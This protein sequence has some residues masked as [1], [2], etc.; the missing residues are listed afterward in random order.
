MNMI[1]VAGKKQNETINYL[2]AVAMLLVIFY[3]GLGYAIGFVG[4]KGK[5]Y[6]GIATVISAVNVPLFLMIAGYLSRPQNVREYYKKR[7]FRILIPFFVFTTVKLAAN[8]TIDR[9]RHSDAVWDEILLAYVYGEY[10][11]FSYAFFIMSLIA[12]LLWKIKNKTVLPVLVLLLLVL[13]VLNEHYHFWSK[14]GLFQIYNVLA[15]GLWFLIGYALQ[16]TGTCELIKRKSVRHTALVLSVI[17]AALISFLLF[18]EMVNKY[19]GRFI[20][21][22]SFS[23]ILYYIFTSIDFRMPLLSGVSKYTYQLFLLD[24]FVKVIL[25]AILSRLLPINLLTVLIISALNV[26]IGV[27]ICLV[28]NKIK[29]AK[30]LLGIT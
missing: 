12:P 22:I 28:A 19:L 13:N 9:F 10:Y 23:Y 5:V 6:D 18:Y 7:I 27:T 14:G 20:G 30:F 24:S 25:F 26:V 16:Q 11:W 15:Y 21:S 1:P 17:A 4:E 2:R 8:L 3:H 29:P